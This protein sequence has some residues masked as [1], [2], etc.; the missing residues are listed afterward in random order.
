MIVESGQDDALDRRVADIPLV[1]QRD[2]LERRQ[3][4][5]PDQARQAADALGQLRIALVRHRARALLAFAEGLLRLEDLRALQAPDLE[6]DLLQRGGGHR[7]HRS[8]TRRG[9]RAAR[10]AWR[11]APAS[12][13]SW[14]HTS[15]SRSGSTWAKLPTAPESLPTEIVARA[16]RRRSRLRPASVVPD[17]HLE[18]EAGRLGVNAVGAADGQGVLVADRQVAQRLA[19]P[20]LPRD[21]QLDRVA[22]LER[23]GGV[24]DVARRQPDVDEARVLA[25]LLLEARSAARSSRA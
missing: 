19:E 18:A 14:R 6:G 13:P 4:V 1:P 20:F 9:G 10:S 16:R 21:Q 5:R 22:E 25:D 8:R 11:R 23:R 7:E 3:R 2:V 24:P 12:R 15:A 17:R